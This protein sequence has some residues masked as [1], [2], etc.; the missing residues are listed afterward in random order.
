ME[1]YCLLSKTLGHN[2]YCVLEIT[3]TSVLPLVSIG[4]KKKSREFRD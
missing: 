2:L 4:N 1:A 3:A